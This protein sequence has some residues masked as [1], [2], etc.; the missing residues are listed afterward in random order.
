MY[1]ILLTDECDYNVE[2]NNNVPSSS[3]DNGLYLNN[4]DFS[5]SSVK[6]HAISYALP[7]SNIKVASVP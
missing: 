1:Y 2:I 4:D 5:I 6:D 3:V 7:E